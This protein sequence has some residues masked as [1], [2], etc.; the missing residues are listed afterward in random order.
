MID[1]EKPKVVKIHDVNIDK[2]YAQWMNDVKARYRS[3]QI[4]AA[5]RVNVEQLQFNWELGRD[6]V[7]KKAEEHWGAGVVE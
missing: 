3:A 2:E 5:V 1:K 7:V 4:K 6:L